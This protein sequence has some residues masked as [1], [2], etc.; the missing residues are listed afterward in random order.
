MSSS[1]VPESRLR[2]PQRM[3]M[4]MAMAALDDLVD[5]QHPVRLL[6]RVVDSLDLSRFHASIKVNVSTV[7]RDATDRRLLVALWLYAATEGIGSARE[8]ASRCESRSKNGRARK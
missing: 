4:T 2:V 3:Q 6:W 1:R 8:L 5:A 7:G